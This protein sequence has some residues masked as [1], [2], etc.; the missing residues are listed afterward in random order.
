MMLLILAMHAYM[1]YRRYAGGLVHVMDDVTFMR[2]NS[3]GS[4]T[5]A[6]RGAVI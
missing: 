5:G 3:H 1:T 2:L 6:S 4:V